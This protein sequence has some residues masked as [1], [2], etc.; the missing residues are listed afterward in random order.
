MASYNIILEN[1]SI[2]EKV[3]DISKKE[4]PII[5][6]I[7]FICITGLVI[8]MNEEKSKLLKKLMTDKLFLTSLT[9]IIVFSI[10]QLWKSGEDS[11]IVR[12]K[13]ATKEA[14]LGLIIAIL[15][16]LDLKAAPFFIIWIISYYLN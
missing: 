15:A 13:K 2:N 10:H 6:I 3:I 14:I 4:T 16:Y 12:R 1:K 5:S 11:E 8:F 9:I 7:G